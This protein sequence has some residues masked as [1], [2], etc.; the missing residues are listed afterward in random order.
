MRT[1]AAGVI[2]MLEQLFGID[3]GFVKE[4]YTCQTLAVGARFSL[5]HSERR[6]ICPLN[7]EVIAYFH[8]CVVE[9]GKPSLW[10]ML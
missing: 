3:V 4:Y 6:W 2:E 8:Q 5:H 7:G 9:T 1:G 10:I